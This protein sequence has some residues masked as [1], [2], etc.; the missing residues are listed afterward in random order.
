MHAAAESSDKSIAFIEG[1]GHKF[2]AVDEKY[3]DT[4]KIL[5]D[6]MDKWLSEPG[7]FIG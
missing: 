2:R 6:F 7:R 5:Y 1:A 4:E 3:G